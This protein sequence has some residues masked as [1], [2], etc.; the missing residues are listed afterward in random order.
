MDNYHRITGIE[1]ET[2]DEEESEVEVFIDKLFGTRVM[3]LT[4]EYMALNGLFSSL[5]EFRS[6]LYDI[7]FTPFSRTVGGGDDIDSSG[8]ETTF[9]AEAKNSIIRNYNWLTFYLDELEEEVDYCGYRQKSEIGIQVWVLI[10]GLSECFKINSFLV[11]GVSP[12]FEFAVYTACFVLHQ[13]E[14]CSFTLNDNAYNVETRSVHSSS[15]D[16]LRIAFFDA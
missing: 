12:E 3:E 2:T 5:S 6:Y 16:I 13:D 14:S 8:F 11:Y 1:E 15:E 9:L 4:Y 10:N 7:W